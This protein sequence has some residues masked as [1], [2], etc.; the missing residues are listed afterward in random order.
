MRN[1]SDFFVKDPNASF[2]ASVHSFFNVP[3]FNDFNTELSRHI[4]EQR[5]QQMMDS[6]P[7]NRNN[8]AEAK[9]SA[10]QALTFF[11]L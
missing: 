7:I 1:P 6:C 4:G 5:R 10:E 2:S 3:E 11:G 9:Y 8:L